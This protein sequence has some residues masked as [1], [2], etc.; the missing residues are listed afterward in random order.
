MVGPALNRLPLLG[1]KVVAL[2]HSHDPRKGLAL[3]VEHTLDH[4]QL[5]A[6]LGH[7]GC[8]SAPKIV[9]NP[10]FLDLHPGIDLVLEVAEPAETMVVGTGKDTVAAANDLRDRLDDGHH[11]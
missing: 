7:A 2:I 11:L 10:R 8:D 5:D 6:D 1:G 4:G 9:E 3:M